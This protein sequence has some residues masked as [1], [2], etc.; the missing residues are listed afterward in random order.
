M[1]E[2][3]SKGFTTNKGA[4]SKNSKGMKVS[5]RK[6][7]KKILFFKRNDNQ[8]KINKIPMHNCNQKKLKNNAVQ[9]NQCF[10]NFRFFASFELDPGFD[11]FKAPVLGNGFDAFEAIW[12]KRHSERR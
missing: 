4:T 9:T 12:V 11:A 2:A 6:D 7:G 5:R 3:K 10:D 1:E 8:F